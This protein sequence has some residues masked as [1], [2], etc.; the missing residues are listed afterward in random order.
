MTVIKVKK[1]IGRH[2]FDS[3]FDYSPI[4]TQIMK[5]YTLETSGEDIEGK[6]FKF[7]AEVSSNTYHGIPFAA[8]GS[9]SS[10]GTCKV[11]WVSN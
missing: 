7:S 9:N 11:V 5:D 8:G 6:L 3:G 4:G 1:L 10:H 2:G